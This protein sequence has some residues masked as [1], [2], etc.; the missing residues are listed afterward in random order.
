MSRFWQDE[1][2]PRGGGRVEDGGGERMWRGVAPSGALEI[3][4]TFH[5]LERLR[6]PSRLQ[7]L[8]ISRAAAFNL[9]RARARDPIGFYKRGKTA[10]EYTDADDCRNGERLSSPISPPKVSLSLSLFFSAMATSRKIFLLVY[11]SHRTRDY[12]P[13]KSS[14]STYLSSALPSLLTLIFGGMSRFGK[15]SRVPSFDCT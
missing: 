5:F 15:L 12:L 3:R 7:I 8:E 4:H 13:A 14:F 11:N 2:T 10:R 9:P 1:G 6:F